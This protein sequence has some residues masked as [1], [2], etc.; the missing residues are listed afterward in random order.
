M[1]K[2][3]YMWLQKFVIVTKKGYVDLLES[4]EGVSYHC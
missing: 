3:P 1:V 4:E 2:D